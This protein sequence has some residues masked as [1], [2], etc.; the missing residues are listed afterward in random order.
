MSRW[1][2]WGWTGRGAQPWSS[3]RASRQPRRPS[4]ESREPSL[5]TAGELWLD[6]YFLLHCIYV[7]L[8]YTGLGVRM[9]VWMMYMYVA[10]ATPSFTVHKLYVNR[11]VRY[12]MWD[13]IDTLM[14][15]RILD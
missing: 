7:S 14:L 10:V 13:A 5:G 4:V 3:M 1:F 9:Y 8:L 12:I 6:L 11:V 15:L 2:D